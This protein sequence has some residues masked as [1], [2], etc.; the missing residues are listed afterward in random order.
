MCGKGGKEKG[1]VW[2]ARRIPN[3]CISGHAN[4]PRIHTF[5]LNDSENCIYAK[6]VIS[7]ARKMKY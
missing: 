1:A 5:P 6:D 4:A 2:V 3:D 7:F